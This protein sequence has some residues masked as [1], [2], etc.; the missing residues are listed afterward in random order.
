MTSKLSLDGADTLYDAPNKIL[1][2]FMF[3]CCNINKIWICITNLTPG[4]FVTKS[5][6]IWGDG[7]LG[8]KTEKQN[9]T[10]IVFFYETFR[11]CYTTFVFASTLVGQI[12]SGNRDLMGFIN[13]IDRFY[14]SESIVTWYGQSVIKFAWIKA[15]MLATL[16]NLILQ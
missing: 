6:N 10:L 11:I 13:R 2:H 3:N 14:C 15:N 4:F 12:T 5:V 9:F 7:S 1:N 16:C 8:T